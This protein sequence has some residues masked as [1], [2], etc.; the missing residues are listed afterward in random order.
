LIAID[1]AALADLRT[2][3]RT[4]TGGVPAHRDRAASLL[5]ESPE[6]LH[7]LSLAA[8]TGAASY[9]FQ[10]PDGAIIERRLTAEPPNR[11]RGD[12]EV[13]ACYYPQARAGEAA[14]WPSLLSGDQA[15]WAW[16]DAERFRW[17]AAP[18]LH[19]LVIEF[20]QNHNSREESI[21]AAIAR[22]EAAIR[23]EHP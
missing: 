3:A 14:A 2:A 23:A 6:Q 11:D 1:G 19:A 15:P 17:R 12:E 4:L 18:E 20:R 5:F 8:Q 7:A 10:M 16:R 9:Q 13:A 21:S 22:F